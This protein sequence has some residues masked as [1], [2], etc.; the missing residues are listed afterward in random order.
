MADASLPSVDE[1]LAWESAQKTRAGL[2]ALVAGNLTLFG[3]I[4]ASIQFQD[5]PKVSGLDGLRDAAGDKLSPALGEGLRTSQLLFY[6]DKAVTLLF[7]AVVLAIGS[8]S[9]AGVLGYLFRATQARNPNLPRMALYG[10]LLGPILLGVSELALQ[11]GIS[12]KAGEF[13][14][15]KD[16]S[17]EA[18]HDAL[19]GGVVLAAQVLRQAGVL[20]MAFSLV[21][22]SLNAMRVGLLTRF[23]GI[24]G[25]IVGALFVIPI[26]GNLPVVQC[27][28]LIAIGF[29]IMDRWPGA[30]GRPPAWTTGKSEPWPTQQELRE[31]KALAGAAARGADPDTDSGSEDSGDG[32][33]VDLG[34]RSSG[35]QTGTDG[36]PGTAARR[37]DGVPHSASKKRKNRKRR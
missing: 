2:L 29:L 17:T 27:F 4:A 37:P 30:V 33:S 16:Y 10:A 7:V 13:V 32:E 26:G 6:D 21:L 11:I 15:G 24:L 28:W 25:I 5:F 22:L 1:T 34:K 14:D 20:L 3:G 12:V 19:Q 18:A 8:A 31:Q 35:P 9:M 23:M 36:L